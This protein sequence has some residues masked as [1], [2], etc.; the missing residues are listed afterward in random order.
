MYISVNTCVKHAEPCRGGGVGSVS[1]QSKL[2]A[3]EEGSI[4][5][6]DL[7]ALLIAVRLG[8]DYTLAN[9]LTEFSLGWFSEHC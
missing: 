4:F 1:W 6:E 8:Y 9:A 5:S 3:V 2:L 7:E